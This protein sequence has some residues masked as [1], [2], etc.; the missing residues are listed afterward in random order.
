MGNPQ[1]IG[2]ALNHALGVATIKRMATAI[3]TAI[4]QS[5]KKFHVLTVAETRALG[6]SRGQVARLVEAGH[7]QRLFRGIYLTHSASPSWFS[8]AHAALLLGGPRAV[9]THESAWFLNGLQPKPPRIITVNVPPTSRLK[10]RPGI[11]FLRHVHDFQPIGRLRRTTPEQTLLD[12]LSL[13]RDPR[14]II[15]LI[16]HAFRNGVKEAAVLD[17]LRKRHRFRN[18]KLVELL[19]E[20]V[21]G[22]TESP[23]EYL[24]DEN[25][26]IPHGLP[27]SEKQSVRVINGKRIRVD[28]RIKLFR[29]LI[30]LDGNLGHPGG[31]TDRDMWRDNANLLKHGD[32]TLR[33]RW[34]NIVSTPCETAAQI[35]TALAINGWRGSPTKC[36]PD[37]RVLDYQL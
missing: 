25:V 15:G 8:K 19:L 27:R 7:W 11:R 28:R 16:T 1:L 9:L 17:L 6:L 32:Q 14:E 21:V 22:G 12:L 29:L 31:P 2:A 24:F 23:L 10:P 13:Q 30:E 3:R 4:E 26:E 37:C 36:S 18:R 34:L 33:Y 20:T 35:A 5:K